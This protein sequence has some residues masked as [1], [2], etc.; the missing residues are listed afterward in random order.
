M[1][2]LDYEAVA[3]GEKKKSLIPRIITSYLQREYA[4]YTLNTVENGRAKKY[5]WMSLEQ[6]YGLS[7]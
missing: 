1:P 2:L 3:L 7:V 4:E 6:P 5:R